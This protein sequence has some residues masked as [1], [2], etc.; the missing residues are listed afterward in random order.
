VVSD[1]GLGHRGSLV[2]VDQRLKWRSDERALVSSGA[3]GCTSGGRAKVKWMRQGEWARAGTSRG[4][5]GR[6]FRVDRLRG[7]GRLV[8]RARGW[9]ARASG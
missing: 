9:P 4:G 5:S 8:V 2:V 1:H 7:H 3:D 6:W